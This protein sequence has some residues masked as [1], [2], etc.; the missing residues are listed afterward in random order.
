MEIGRRLDFQKLGEHFYFS[1]FSFFWGEHTSIAQKL[2]LALYSGITPG[3]S[4][5]MFGVLGI[6]LRSTM[7]KAKVP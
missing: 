1:F 7:S 3:S 5:V 4:G 2:P 6:E